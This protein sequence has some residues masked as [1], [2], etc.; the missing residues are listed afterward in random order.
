MLYGWWWCC[1][2]RCCCSAAAVVG[3]ST[4][5]NYKCI[6]GNEQSPRKVFDSCMRLLLLLALSLTL[7]L[8]WILVRTLFS[9]KRNQLLFKYLIEQRWFSTEECLIRL[10]SVCIYTKRLSERASI[11]CHWLRY[12]LVRFVCFYINLILIGGVHW[13]LE[14]CSSA[15]NEQFSENNLTAIKRMNRI[16]S[17]SMNKCTMIN[18][19]FYLPFFERMNAKRSKKCFNV[20]C[21]ST[22]NA[23]KMN[24]S[25]LHS[26][27]SLQFN[28]LHHTDHRQST[29]AKTSS[30]FT[31]STGLRCS[32]LCSSGTTKNAF[33][34]L[35]MPL[36]WFIHAQE[37]NHWNEKDEKD[38]ALFLDRL[39]FTIYKR[40][41]FIYFSSSTSLNSFSF[42]VAFLLVLFFHFYL[43]EATFSENYMA[44]IETAVFLCTLHSAE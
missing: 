43:G 21:F 14:R 44:L 19:A 29:L 20:F 16:D 22:E 11:C 24:I 3:L 34:R 23:N 30:S 1:R 26:P 32:A 15:F 39:S 2:R 41:L 8:P 31:F 17:Q 35:S 28:W 7:A 27:R 5:F 25:D 4:A 40:F 12:W 37:I 36:A 42:G 18:W 13:L 10:L 6:G 9:S 38:K 33:D